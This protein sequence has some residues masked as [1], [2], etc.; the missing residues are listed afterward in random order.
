MRKIALFFEK[1]LKD[2][3]KMYPLIPN[4]MKISAIAKAMALIAAASVRFGQTA[5]IE[6]DALKY[7]TSQ[8]VFYL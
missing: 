1:I 3:L 7:C 5:H 8:C 6:T 4:I 2:D